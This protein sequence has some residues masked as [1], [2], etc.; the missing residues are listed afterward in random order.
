M[1]SRE[2]KLRKLR[3]MQE[4]L[5]NRSSLPTIKKEDLVVGNSTMALNEL[6]STKNQSIDSKVENISSSLDV[7]KHAKEVLEANAK[8]RVEVVFIIDK[9][10]S[11]EGTETKVSKGIDKIIAYQ[12]KQGRNPLIT[13][14]L[15]NEDIEVVYNRLPIDAAKSIEYHADGGTALYDALVYQIEKTKMKQSLDINKIEHTIVAIC[16]DGM[17]N[18]SRHSRLDARKL[19][20]ERKNNGWEFLFL[21]TNFDV[22]DEALKL[23]IN[24]K[25]AAKYNVERLEDNFEAITKALNDVYEQG[26]VSE[27]WS[28]PIKNNQLSSGENKQYKKLLG[29]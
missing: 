13:T 4:K 14:L 23:G 18:E 24:S 9:S 11:V 15:F 22:L 10:G 27:D 25:Y 19:I 29:D 1:E 12:K 2:D 21:G 5:K 20:E 26:H 3:E 28:N 17:D 8:K 6:T 7:L 16:T